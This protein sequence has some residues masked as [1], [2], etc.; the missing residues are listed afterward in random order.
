M[1]GPSTE[2][3]A[4]VA[5]P[6]EHAAHGVRL[7]DGEWVSFGRPRPDHIQPRLLDSQGLVEAIHVLS[8]KRRSAYIELMRA[9]LLGAGTSAAVIFVALLILWFGP[10]SFLDTL[11]GRGIATVWDMAVWWLVLAP[12]AV[13]AAGFST[14]SLAR[15]LREVQGWRVR[16]GEVSRRLGDARME[17]RRRAGMM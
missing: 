16:A 6:D 8:L 13:I 11:K 5:A 17:L 14:I 4:E 9:H 1:A 2:L 3:L 10:A 15:R 7:G 12:L